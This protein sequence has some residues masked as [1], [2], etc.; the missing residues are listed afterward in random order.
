MD[1]WWALARVPVMHVDMQVIHVCIDAS[2]TASACIC[3]CPEHLHAGLH[4]QSRSLYPSEP[5]QGPEHLLMYLP[6]ASAALHD[7]VNIATLDVC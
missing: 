6:V 5:Y 3:V 1:I 4:V 7:Q 2:A